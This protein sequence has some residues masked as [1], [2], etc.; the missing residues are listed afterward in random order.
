MPVPAGAKCWV[1]RFGQQRKEQHAGIRLGQRRFVRK[2]G[3]VIDR[4]NAKDMTLG[5][6]RTT[7]LTGT[8]RWPAGDDHRFD[9]RVRQYFFQVGHTLRSQSPALQILHTDS[10]AAINQ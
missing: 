6:Q 1:K 7:Q 8:P 4:A 10:I 9:F 5:L 3:G 2:V